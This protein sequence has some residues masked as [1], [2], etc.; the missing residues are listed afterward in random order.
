[1]KLVLLLADQSTKSLF[2]KKDKREKDK[3]RGRS[4][5]NKKTES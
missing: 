3:D 5:S 2:E 4:S 1:M